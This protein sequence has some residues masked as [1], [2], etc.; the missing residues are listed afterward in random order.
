MEKAHARGALEEGDDLG[1][2]PRVLDA[3]QP[4]LERRAGHP[5][6]SREL[7]LRE[8]FAVA[9]GQEVGDCADAART[10]RLTAPTGQ[11]LQERRK[12]GTFGGR[13]VIGAEHAW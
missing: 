8:P 2:Q 9:G 13:G 11:R 4:A 6:P 10:R 7:A 3:S 5:R 12:V 1:L